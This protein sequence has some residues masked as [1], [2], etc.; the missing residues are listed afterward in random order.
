RYPVVPLGPVALRVEILYDFGGQARQ[1]HRPD[2]DVLEVGMDLPEILHGGERSR[3]LLS[4]SLLELAVQS[5][6][7]REL[8]GLGLIEAVQ[9]EVAQKVRILAADLIDDGIE[10]AEEPVTAV[11]PRTQL[12]VGAFF[13]SQEVARDADQV[14]ERGALL[15]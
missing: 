6:H 10:A 4:V 2:I 12:A 7:G 15:G 1:E 9:H 8:G 5:V 13:E 3:D 11:R 14:V